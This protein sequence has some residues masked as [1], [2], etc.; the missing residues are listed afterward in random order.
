MKDAL[1]F[2]IIL[3][4]FLAGHFSAVAR[5]DP[6]PPMADDYFPKRWKEFSSQE[7]GFTVLLPGTPQVSSNTEQTQSG[8]LVTHT[9]S[10]K[11]LIECDVIY[12]DCPI[13]VEDPSQVKKLFD[14]MRDGGLANVAKGNPRLIKETDFSISGHPGRFLHIDVAENTVIRMKFIAVKK[15]VYSLVAASEKARPNV[16]GY[17]NDYQEIAMAFLDSFK[18]TKF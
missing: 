14:Y 1:R 9:F 7:G 6:P 12:F 4:V 11:G 18:L 5:Q 2:A 15:R 17:E 3:F 16:M 8:Q 13:N 10:Y